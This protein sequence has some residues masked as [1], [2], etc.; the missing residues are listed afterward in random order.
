MAD[1]EAGRIDWGEAMSEFKDGGPAFPRPASNVVNEVGLH[2]DDGDVGMTLRDYLA[3]K[4]M[5]SYL[6]PAGPGNT[7][8]QRDELDY[9]AETAY[10]AA[11]A[12][13]KAR[14]PRF[15]TTTCSQC[16]RECGPGDSGVSHCGDHS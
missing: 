1:A 11:D 12:M 9:I 16:G 6:I 15:E 13:L 2:I 8:A 3:A 14:Q 5:A 10:L 4:A 7:W